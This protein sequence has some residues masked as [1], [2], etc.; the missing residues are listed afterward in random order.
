[1]ESIGRRIYFDVLT[2][3]I[4]TDIGER[5][6]AVTTTTVEQDTA[7]YKALSERHRN[8]FDFIELNYG[9][10]SQDFLE[11]SG[12]SVDPSSQEIIFAYPDPNEPEVEQPYRPPL[13]TEVDE[14]KHENV[15]LKAQNNALS[16]RADFVED[17]IAEM[18]MQ[19]YQ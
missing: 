17:L 19:V 12:Y 15:I 11:C 8:T 1:M 10:Y 18:A 5:Y 7:N 3:D 14:L 13:S 4:I 6:G 16:E 9:E 2:G